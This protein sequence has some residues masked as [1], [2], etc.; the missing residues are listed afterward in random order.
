MNN[1]LHLLLVED[2]LELQGQLRRRFE[3]LGHRVHATSD[4]YEALYYAKEYE[5]DLAIIDLGLPKIDGIDLIKR[6]RDDDHTFPTLILTARSGWK[7]KVV[8]LDSGADDYLTKPF[9][10]EEL[11]ARVNALIRRA[12][13]STSSKLSSG[14][15]TLD[16]KTSGVFVN[17]EEVMLTAFEFTVLEYFLRNQKKII[18]KSMLIDRLYDGDDDKDSNVLEV[19]IARLRKKLDPNGDHPPIETLRGRGYRWQQH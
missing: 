13:G 18:T 2:D 8:G 14:P 3:R 5:V 12:S 17:G 1:S 7:A 11:D 9:Q 6:L 15:Y 16:L 19:I 4:G 10:T